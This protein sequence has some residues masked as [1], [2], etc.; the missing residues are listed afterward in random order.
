MIALAFANHD[1]LLMVIKNAEFAGTM[2]ANTK[3]DNHL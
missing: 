1:T 3:S 2:G